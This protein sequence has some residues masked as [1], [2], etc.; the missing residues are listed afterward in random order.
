MES[1]RA[2]RSMLGDEVGDGE[3]GVAREDALPIS[4]AIHEASSISLNSSSSGSGVI[5][6]WTFGDALAKGRDALLD[7]TAGTHEGAALDG[8]DS[9][10][11]V[12]GVVVCPPFENVLLALDVV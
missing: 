10:S 2:R 11:D 9:S 6:I 3:V 8:E 12:T 5:G 1:G 4:S 7:L